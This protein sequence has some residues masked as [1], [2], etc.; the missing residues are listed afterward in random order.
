MAYSEEQRYWIWL[1]SVQGLGAKRFDALLE[2]VGRPQQVWE[3][4]GPFMQPIVGAQAFSA[5]QKARNPRYFDRLFDK[6]LRSD[7]VAVTRCDPEYPARLRTIH[8]APPTLFVRGRIVLEDVCTLAIV[9]ARNSTAYGMRMARRIARELSAAGVT[10]VSGLARGIDSAAHR[11]AVD[12]GARTVAVLG[13]GVDVI[14]PPEHLMLADEI[15]ANGGSLLS[16]CPPGAAPLRHH[17][18]ARNR[19]ITGMS[20]GMLLIEAAAGSG[21][22]STVTFAAEQGRELLAI[23]GQVDNP[24]SALP[25]AL[26]RDG[27]KLVTSAQ[28]II[29]EMGW[30]AR[31]VPER[32]NKAARALPLTQSEQQ[33]YNLLRGGPTD[34]DALVEAL[35]MPAP[36]LNALITL[37][38]LR[39]IVRKLPG[40]RVERV[41]DEEGPS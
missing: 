26:I 29:A 9:G 12:A 23:P 4:C 16:E 3:E 17:F 1:S 39:G 2:R 31:P 24:L 7:A 28:E 36:E 25:H 37:L 8:D 40:R 30:Q 22:R 18:P 6:L 15:L 10:V 34:T 38:E 13:C 5:L 41:D 11:G 19:I 14:Y 20:E 35:G 27:A 33:L 21:T 32:R